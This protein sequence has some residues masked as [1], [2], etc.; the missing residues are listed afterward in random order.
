M[1]IGDEDAAS[2][3]EPLDPGEWTLRD[4]DV[5]AFVRDATAEVA[6]LVRSTLGPWGMEKLIHTQD[7]K[8]RPEIVQTAD[9]GEILAALERSENLTHPIAAV[10]I[11]HVDS[12]QR[13][14]NDGT[15]TAILLAEALITRGLDL[16]EHGVNP[17]NVVIGY[18]LAANRAGT[19]LDDLARPVSADDTDLLHAVAK[20][21]MTALD[22]PDP[23]RDRYSDRV[24]T[25]IQGLDAA[26]ED[27]WLE[28]DD[29]KVL[30]RRGVEDTLYRGLVLR[31]WPGPGDKNEDA[32]IEFDDDLAFPDRTP[33]IT[34][35]LVEGEI[36][37]GETASQL[38]EQGHRG[39]R[40]T[41]DTA[42]E[43]GTE[44]DRLARG[45]AARLIDLDT[46]VVVTQERLDDRIKRHFEAAGLAVID[47]AKYPQ[48][49]IHRLARAT[50]GRVE[51]RVTDVT[52]ESLGT[53][54]AVEE[55]WVGD[56]RW[57]VFD[58]CDGAVFT[59]V[60]DVVG[61]VAGTERER[62][63]DDAIGITGLAVIDGQVLPGAGAP[64]MAV[65]A[66]LRDYAPSI[67]D[68][69]QLAVEAFA[70]ALESLVG[71][72]A[73]NAGLD[74]IDA[75]STLRAQTDD[76]TV[77]GLDCTTGGA[78]D[79]WDAGVV[80]PRRVFSQAI[81]TARAAVEQLVTVDSVLYPGVD[82]AAL[83]PITEHE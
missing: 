40:L 75:I 28:T 41:P 26:A 21:S 22:L 70:D 31:R 37:F 42:V 74:P 16:V 48:T 82:F 57:T 34:A 43:Y 69:S 52:A 49:D 54:G 62:L 7:S 39:V 5:R 10:F 29:V 47:G 46:D 76:T 12:M 36:A 81:E 55:Y 45:T 61:D 64:A 56:E 44:R 15:T 20:T 33:D 72:L 58:D 78:M 14:L 32:D 3:R 2:G 63:V 25:A 1:A 38:Y 6:S 27:A 19:V 51:P 66:D 67:S 71:D 8:G 13:G 11:D 4:D 65:A 80:E 30:A 50:G 53:A 77:V 23:V 60:V 35:A 9:G 18:A 17:V 24:V 73:K 59:L 68:E 79:P 83:D